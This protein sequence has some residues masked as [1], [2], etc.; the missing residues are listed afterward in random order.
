MKTTELKLTRSPSPAL[1]AS[2]KAIVMTWGRQRSHSLL[3][4][5]VPRAMVNTLPARDPGHG[6]VV[7]VGG[8]S[9][10]L[11]LSKAINAAI[12][13]A[14][15][16]SVVAVGR[17]VISAGNYSSSSLGFEQHQEVGA[18]GGV[19]GSS[20]DSRKHRHPTTFFCSRSGDLVCSAFLSPVRQRNKRVRAHGRGTEYLRTGMWAALYFP[21]ARAAWARYK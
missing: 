10:G 16:T 17:V 21:V 18:A 12:S 15:A 7:A 20:P 2:P 1:R 9:C 6:E 8:H 19:V 4:R 14:T 11:S 3:P 5:H 13:I